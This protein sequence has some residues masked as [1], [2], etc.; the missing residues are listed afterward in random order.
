VSAPSRTCFACLLLA[1]ASACAPKVTVPVAPRPAVDLQAGAAEVV[2]VAVVARDRRC[3]PVADALA[4]ALWASPSLRVDP[5]AGARLEV[6]LCGDDLQLSVDQEG[7]GEVADVRSSTAVLARAHALLVV[8]DGEA[9]KA[10]LIGTGRSSASGDRG[11]P[12]LGRSARKLA[13]HDV[14]RDLA[15]QLSPG[16]TL[17]ARRVY[18]RAPSTSARGLTTLAVRAEQAG[19]LAEALGWAVAAHEEKPTPRTAGYLYDLKRRAALP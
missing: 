11:L 6:A 19:D 4:E 15:Q 1:G 8:R 18:P 3:Q 16:P 12:G 13:R 7:A 5:G 9:V 17:V 14:A 10:H 2:P